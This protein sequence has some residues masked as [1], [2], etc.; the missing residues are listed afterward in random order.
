MSHL[1]YLEEKIQKTLLTEFQNTWKKGMDWQGGLEA[2]M[3]YDVWTNFK[4]ESEGAKEPRNETNSDSLPV[5]EGEDDFIV[6][7]NDEIAEDDMAKMI[8]RSRD[9]IFLL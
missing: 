8:K 6:N 1:E 4:T 3:F 9:H 7:E 2:S 5:R